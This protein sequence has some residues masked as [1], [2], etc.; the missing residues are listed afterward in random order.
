ME[1]IELFNSEELE[2][3]KSLKEYAETHPYDVD[4]M[5]GIINKDVPI[6]GNTEEYTRFIR[7]YKIVYTNDTQPFGL[8]R[9]MSIS[10][11]DKSEPNLHFIQMTM[12]I[13]GFEWRTHE[14][15]LFLEDGYALNILEPVDK[16]KFNNY[17]ENEKIKT[18]EYG[19][20]SDLE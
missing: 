8:C 16:V 19:C 3:L 13:L 9:H 6:P 17:I 18:Q 5:I 14:C 4:S 15:F 11:T 2:A 7:D 12:I 1:I 10:N 20:D